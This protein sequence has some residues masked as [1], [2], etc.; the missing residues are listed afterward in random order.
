MLLSCS[1]RETSPLASSE[2]EWQFRLP[3]SCQGAPELIRSGVDWRVP[4][5]RDDPCR[6]V[7]DPGPL[8]EQATEL[9][10]GVP[11]REVLTCRLHPAPRWRPCFKRRETSPHPC[12]FLHPLGHP[13]LATRW[14]R[15][16]GRPVWLRARHG[17]TVAAIVCFSLCGHSWLAGMAAAVQHGLSSPG[18]VREPE[19]PVVIEARFKRKGAMPNLDSGGT[20]EQ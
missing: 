11:C 1:A 18:N 6:K 10:T 5:W 20:G 16:R 19:E 4:A 14:C 9:N 12:R 3:R 17:P 13:R 8:V 15:R 2:T 7:R